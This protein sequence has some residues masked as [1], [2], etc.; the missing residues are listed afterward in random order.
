MIF[1]ADKSLEHLTRRGFF[2]VAGS[3]AAKVAGVTAAGELLSGCATTPFAG[4]SYIVD[5][6]IDKRDQ[7]EVY[8][9]ERDLDYNLMRFE[10]ALKTDASGVSRLA[11]DARKA[12]D[13]YLSLK[14]SLNKHQEKRLEWV[15]QRST[16]LLAWKMID[17]MDRD[18]SKLNAGDLDDLEND[19]ARLH[20]ASELINDPAGNKIVKDKLEAYLDAYCDL[21]GSSKK[22]KWEVFN[23][24][25]NDIAEEKAKLFDQYLL[26][27]VYKEATMVKG[28]AG[29]FDAAGKLFKDITPFKD[30]GY[31][32]KNQDRPRNIDKATTL[33]ETD[34]KDRTLFERLFSKFENRMVKYY[35]GHRPKL[36]EV[37]ELVEEDEKTKEK[38]TIYRIHVNAPAVKAW[39]ADYNKNL[40]AALDQGTWR[41]AQCIK[42]S[43]GIER[44]IQLE[45]YNK[46]VQSREGG[47]H[48]LK[49]DELAELK[50][51]V[52]S[53][54]DT[55]GRIQ[56]GLSLQEAE[57]AERSYQKYKN[58][59]VKDK[60]KLYDHLTMA[61]A[62][63]FTA[64]LLATTEPDQERFHAQW[65]YYKKVM[66]G[67]VRVT[68]EGQEKLMDTE[69]G[70]ATLR[71]SY[72]RALHPYID[73][74]NSLDK[75]VGNAAFWAIAK[76]LYGAAI[77]TSIIA[78]PAASAS[79]AG[80]GGG[81]A[82]VYAGGV[83]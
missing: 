39:V 50:K 74:L 51:T 73:E 29:V 65:D 70:K 25:D 16:G 2:R 83:I 14:D 62:R 57:L 72:I 28:F 61:V 11:R 8:S 33:D 81:N 71:D 15:I 60:E 41:D 21:S 17:G 18:L 69:K 40:A 52:D 19:L 20:I 3:T 12:R 26:R 82:L 10:N 79:V 53:L 46:A 36:G 31:V 49:K 30:F 68:S 5:N 27:D 54:T 55:E 66:K 35:Q 47:K 23:R 6:H 67:I 45:R 22:K 77:A 48:Y 64:Y 59:K 75:R 38:K 7:D 78:G 34:S 37:E 43:V 80:G 1:M 76:T 56:T 32:F 42:R 4:G 63:S 58:T 13:D 9:Y 24:P 44:R